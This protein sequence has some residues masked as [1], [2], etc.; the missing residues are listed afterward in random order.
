MTV[1]LWIILSLALIFIFATVIVNLANKKPYG[2]ISR[3]LPFFALPAGFIIKS[4][5]PKA[6]KQLIFGSLW[7]LVYWIFLLD[8]ILIMNNPI[9]SDMP[10]KLSFF[11]LCNETM[12]VSQPHEWTK[13]ALNIDEAVPLEWNHWT[14]P[15]SINPEINDSEKLTVTSIM[16]PIWNPIMLLVTV[17]LSIISFGGI[18]WFSKISFFGAKHMVISSIKFGVVGLIILFGWI[19]GDLWLFGEFDVVLGQGDTRTFINANDTGFISSLLGIFTFTFVLAIIGIFI[20]IILNLI[21]NFTNHGSSYFIRLLTSFGIICGA[22]LIGWIIGDVWLF[23]DVYNTTIINMLLGVF[24]IAII[25]SLLGVF[26]SLI[27]K[28]IMN[29][30]NL[31]WKFIRKI[32]FTFLGLISVVSFSIISSDGTIGGILITMTL[33]LILIACLLIVW[34][35]I[36]YFVRTINTNI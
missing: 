2:L 18:S 20:S 12:F 13:L 36:A 17:F 35:M 21:K 11:E 8:V 19:I 34:G 30:I 6:G 29:I 3:L 14:N 27:T 7:G 16:G 15:E 5:D 32:L 31:G 33:Y 10:N 28:I 23:N 22:I 24:I 26:V 25:S 4:R 9:N 1:I